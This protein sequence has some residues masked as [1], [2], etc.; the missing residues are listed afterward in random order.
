MSA[1]ILLAR[2]LQNETQAHSI[3]VGDT[4][5]Y[6]RDLPAEAE[7]V[8]ELRGERFSLI[9]V[10]HRNLQD[11]PL[12]FVESIRRWQ[13]DTPVL[14]V[15]EELAL[16]NVIRAIRVGVKDLFH[17]PIDLRAMVERIYTTLKPEL[18]STRSAR[19]DEWSELMMQLTDADARPPVHGSRAGFPGTG[20]PM[21]LPAPGESDQLAIELKTTRDAMTQA[22]ARAMELEQEV[23]RLRTAPPFPVPGRKSAADLKIETDFEA[24]REKLETEQMLL[25]QA[26]KK[27]E[28][29]MATR[30]TTDT[31]AR[32]ENVDLAKR[33]QALAEKSRQ[34]DAAQDRLQVEMQQ[35]A[36][37]KAQLEEERSETGET[38]AAQ[39]EIEVKMKQL[40]I[41]QVA[42]AK[43]KEKHERDTAA[44]QAA[45]AK[46][47]AELI[48]REAAVVQVQKQAEQIVV[49]QEK[50]ESAQLLLHQATAKLERERASW[51][52]TQTQLQAE[53]KVA[54]EEAHARLAT[55]ETELAHLKKSLSMKE[56]AHNEAVEQ[57][58]MDQ[59]KWESERLVAIQIQAKFAKDRAALEKTAAAVQA[60]TEQIKAQREALAAE[61]RKSADEIAGRE[62]QLARALKDLGPKK[63]ELEAAQQKLETELL[64]TK[65]NL[66]K[67]AAARNE[68]EVLREDL[69]HQTKTL[70]EREAAMNEAEVLMQ[71]QM[72]QAMVKQ[73][74]IEQEQANYK[75]NK[76]SLNQETA[77]LAE[78]VWLFE[79]KQKQIK[80][81]MKQLLAAGE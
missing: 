14:V 69:Q 77:A 11:D 72:D 68:V 15:S 81:Q 32:A 17:H 25:T 58:T 48:Q 42:L 30:K 75:A 65:Q 6:W 80:E 7:L 23:T 70:A 8:A 62:D 63:A 9:I 47:E 12:A 13:K 44:S 79:S 60:E 33:E 2:K 56:A 67:A 37:A 78:R 59:E 53:A 45:L 54:A 74:E 35:L 28:T 49:E 50:L 51:S 34:L 22:K 31:V 61:Q 43:A 27:F 52:Q 39:K 38:R 55:R 71:N 36:D 21:A 73:A 29:E 46:T 20:M 16:E 76:Q 66:A 19:L 64:L 4:G 57:F 40:V 10:D 18:G 24:D 41:E 1:K 26:R 5:F 3:L